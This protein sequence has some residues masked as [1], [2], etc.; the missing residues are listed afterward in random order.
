KDGLDTDREGLHRKLNPQKITCL[1]LPD[2]TADQSLKDVH[3][4]PGDVRDP[5]ACRKFLQGA[6]GGHLFH[7]AGVIHP[8][9]VRDFEEINHLGTVNLLKA[10]K[11]AGIKRVT[12]MSSNSPIGCNPDPSQLFD[13]DSPYHPYMGYGRSKM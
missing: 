2:Q 8:K 5:E 1:V 10:A 4:I 9:S 11:E 6:E 12:L 13:E 7:L 3:V